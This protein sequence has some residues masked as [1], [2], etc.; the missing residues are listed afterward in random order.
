MTEPLNLELLDRAHGALLGLAAGDASGFPSRYHRMARAGS[1]R[2]L[3]WSQAAELDGQRINKFPLP[4]THAVPLSSEDFSATDDAEQAV[5]SAEV[6]LRA[7]RGGSSEPTTAELFAAWKDIVMPQADRLWG[8]VADRSAIL[9]A[10]SGLEAPVTGSDNPHYYDDSA[11]AKSLPV[12]IRYAGQPGAAVRVARNLASITNDAEGA[13]AAAAFGAAI[14]VLVGGGTTSEGMARGA[15]E[16][17][18]DSWLGRKFQLAETIYTESGSLIDAIPRWNDEVA[19][20]EYNFGNVA[21]ETLPLALIIARESRSFAEA[22]GIANLVPKQADTMPAMVGA[23]LGATG[24]TTAIPATWRERIETLR[25][26]GVPLT[27]G[28]QLRV[29]AERLLTHE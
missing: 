4:Y 26:Y 28:M 20:L 25:G 1:R 29:V 11:V 23:L 24:G 22:I 10:Q 13:D 21:A 2:G 17:H 3:L 16:I 7:L 12:A 8:S 14:A 9:N 18:S 19:N 6:L 27:K 15:D 5:L